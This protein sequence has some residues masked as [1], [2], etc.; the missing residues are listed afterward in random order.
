MLKAKSKSLVGV[1]AVLSSCGGDSSFY[2]IGS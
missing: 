1:D 2:A